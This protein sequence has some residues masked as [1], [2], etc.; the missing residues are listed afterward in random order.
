MIELFDDTG[1][2]LETLHLDL[3]PF[4]N[5]QLNQVFA[6]HAPVNGAADVW[7]VKPDATFTCYG[8]LLDNGT[9]DPT[10]ILPQ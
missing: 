7:T 2:S 1:S 5:D 3:S 10:T 6:D 9:N 8:S 4:S